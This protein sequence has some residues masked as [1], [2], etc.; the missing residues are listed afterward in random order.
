M[1]MATMRTVKVIQIRNVPDEVHRELRARAAAE[2][3]SLSDFALRELER[4]TARPTLADVIA[5][6]QARS[7]SVSSEDL[8]AAVR[9]ARG[10]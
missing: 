8:V 9:A 1:R 5:R 10:E 2:G 4:V 3:L 6:A 7:G